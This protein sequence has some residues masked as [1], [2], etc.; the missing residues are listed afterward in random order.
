MQLQPRS[1]NSGGLELD[2]TSIQPRQ[3]LSPSFGHEENSLLHY[4]QLLRKRAWWIL[5]V[6]AIV[7]TLSVISTLRA[8]RLYQ[9]TSMIAISPESPDMLGA[10]QDDNSPTYYPYQQDLETEAAMLRSDV[11]ATRVIDVMHLDR[12]PRFTGVKTATSSVEEGI[13]T[14]QVESDPSRVA[15][16]M[17]AFHGGLSVQIIPGS[18]LIEVSCT[19]SDPRMAAEIANTLVR[20]FIEENFKTKYESVTQTSDWLTKQLADLQL[21]MQA[22]EEKLV[23]YQKDHGILGGD[24]KQNIV[25]AKLDE[26]NRELTAAETDRIQKESDYR[27]AMEGDPSTFVKTTAGHN[28][29]LLDKLQEKQ[30]DL[31]TQLAQ[32]TT[33]FGPAYPKVIALNNQLKQVQ[34]EVEAE[35]RR[36]QLKLRDE[37]L[38][39]LE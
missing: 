29:T 11:L 38:A 21:R 26:L 36:M 27:L 37:Y 25:T 34:V 9:A 8:T 20:E 5:A 15:S 33:Q 2:P 31:N 35:K 7:F 30:S 22:S 4:V 14:S 19:H 23:R 3:V 32:L 12:D 39:A 18:Q 16:L 17:G 10:K 1:D 6:L 13:P 28:D 24:D